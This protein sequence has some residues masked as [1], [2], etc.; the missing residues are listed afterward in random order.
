M[1]GV[2]ELTW[3]TLDRKGRDFMWTRNG[4]A[5]PQQPSLHASAVEDE[6]EEWTAGVDAEEPIEDCGVWPSW[7]EVQQDTQ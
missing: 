6:L 2:D 5:V 4:V 3:Q 1:R 7:D